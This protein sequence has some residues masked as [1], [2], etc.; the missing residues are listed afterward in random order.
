VFIFGGHDRLE[1]PRFR[2]VSHVPQGRGA[3]LSSHPG[4]FVE[5]TAEDGQVGGPPGF[6]M[7]RGSGD[8]CVFLQEGSE[9]I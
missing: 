1:I 3:M 2:G 7:V 5:L 9:P 4:G 6:G 8:W